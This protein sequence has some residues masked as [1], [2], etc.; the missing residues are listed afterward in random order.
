[1][2]VSVKFLFLELWESHGISG[3]KIV[4]DRGDG[5]YRRTKPSASTKQGG[6]Y[7]LTETKAACPGS[8]E[9]CTRS[10]MYRF[11]SVYIIVN[12]MWFLTLRIRGSLILLPVLGTFSTI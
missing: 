6:A 9:V 4:R 8:T 10:S 12:F 2:E 1:M 5:G 7:E 11:Y 3:A